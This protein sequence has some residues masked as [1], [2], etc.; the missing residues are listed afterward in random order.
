MVVVG[1]EYVSYQ[2]FIRKYIRSDVV[3]IL[4]YVMWQIVSDKKKKKSLY[5]SDKQLVTLCHIG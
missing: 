3:T 5:K 2:F 1:E 4:I